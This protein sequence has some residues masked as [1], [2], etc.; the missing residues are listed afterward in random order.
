[1]AL[2]PP[3]PTVPS[4][5]IRALTMTAVAAG[6]LAACGSNGSGDRAPSAATAAPSAAAGGPGPGLPQGTEPVHL[7]PAVFTTRIDNR[8]WPMA[9]GTR[10]VYSE[11]G[12]NGRKQRVTVTV[13][14][15]TKT[16]AAGVRARVVHDEVT[17]GGRVIENT[18]DWY[19]QDRAGNIWYLGEDTT[20]FGPGDKR[21]R[22]GSW[23]A[24]VDG[25][26]AGV[27]MPAR[28]RVGLRYRQ[29]Y[30][31]GHAEDRAEIASLHGRAR[32]PAGAYGDALV[33]RDSNP[34][35]GGSVEHKYYAKGVGPVLGVS[36]GGSREQLVRFDRTPRGG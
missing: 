31:E 13:T 10:W 29:E 16:V 5:R 24:G 11:D 27:I 28:P 20:E 15:R 14:A 32:V 34:L 4:M 30:Y 17:Q 3:A 2:S 21:S 9:I 35:G 25:G 19:A 6:L 23:E 8:Y 36:R 33:T 1:M 18:Y 26:Q 12:E 7:D 22:E